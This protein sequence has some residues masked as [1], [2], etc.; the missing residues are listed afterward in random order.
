[1]YKFTSQKGGSSDRSDPLSYAPDEKSKVYLPDLLT[2]LPK[3]FEPIHLINVN[4]Q[5]LVFLPAPLGRWLSDV[6]CPISGF[7]C[8]GQVRNALC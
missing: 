3:A 4:L 6:T 7:T 1:M 8:P 5:T 2:Y